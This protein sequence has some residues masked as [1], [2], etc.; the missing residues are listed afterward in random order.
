M[1][2]DELTHHRFLSLIYTHTYR[3]HHRVVDRH[4]QQQYLPHPH[5]VHQEAEEEEHLHQAPRNKAKSCSPFSRTFC[6]VR[7]QVP[8][9][10][11]QEEE[12]VILVAEQGG[13]NRG[14]TSVASD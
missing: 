2:V 14:Q 12:V 8:V 10:V 4:Q 1:F 7:V 9:V 13:R 3:N 5:P 6:V 11:R